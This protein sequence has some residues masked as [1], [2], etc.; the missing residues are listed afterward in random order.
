MNIHIYSF[1]H[2]HTKYLYSLF[3][4]TQNI[5]SELFDGISLQLLSIHW[6]SVRVHFTLLC[7]S[8]CTKR[9]TL[10]RLAFLSHSLSRLYG[11]SR[12]NRLE[13]SMFFWITY[14]FYLFG[15]Q[16]NALFEI[17]RAAD[18]QRAKEKIWNVFFDRTIYIFS[19][20]KRKNHQKTVHSITT[21]NECT[22]TLVEVTRV[23]FS[24]SPM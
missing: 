5:A 21:N 8:V 17:L 10:L 11:C 13:K 16:K 4:S 14:A 23:V 19:N 9:L 6:N 7:H 22:V 12:I 20:G 1:T 15:V 18:A 3:H 2:T 24:L